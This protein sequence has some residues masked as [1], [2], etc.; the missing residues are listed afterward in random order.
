[1][2]TRL[3]LMSDTHLPGRARDL[4]AVLWDAVDAA[5]VARLS[6]LEV[7][8]GRELD[9]DAVLRPGGVEVVDAQHRVVV[10]RRADAPRDQRAIGARVG[11]A[12]EQPADRVD[13][14]PIAVAIALGVG[15]GLCASRRAPE[16]GDH[17]EGDRRNVSLSAPPSH[18]RRSAAQFDG[19]RMVAS[20]RSTS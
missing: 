11:L 19:D 7:A 17:P 18:V 3:L 6:H 5:D 2:T 9:V 16:G 12:P 1:M 8:P 14:G 13:L 10:E 15:G 20:S 4:P